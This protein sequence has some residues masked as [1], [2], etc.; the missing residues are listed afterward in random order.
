MTPIYE[1]DN[2]H[3]PASYRPISLTSIPC[4]IM[5]ILIKKAI[6][7]HLQRNNLISDMQYGFLPGRSC[8]TNLLLFTDSLTQ[9]WDNGPISDAVFF[10]F[11]KAFGKVLHKP[12]LHKLQPY[13]VCGELLQWINSSLTDR[14]FCVKVDQT[15]T[16]PAAVHSGVPQGSVLG[17]LLFL[18]NINDLTDVISSRSLFYADDLKSWTSNNPDVLQEDIISIKNWSTSW[19]L[20]INDTK[21]AHMPPGRASGN[22]FIIYDGA[23]VNFL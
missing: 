21:C 22:R 13:R 15:L 19:S 7:D 14:S 16:P 10:D 8:S 9:A 2:R 18:V 5:E 11:A 4:K 3:L 20:P 1:S 17:P 23:E 12:L 6:L